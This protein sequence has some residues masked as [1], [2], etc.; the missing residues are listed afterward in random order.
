[1]QIGSFAKWA[2]PNACSSGGMND[3]VDNAFV[4]IETRDPAGMTL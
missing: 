4:F 3:V 1:M 2:N